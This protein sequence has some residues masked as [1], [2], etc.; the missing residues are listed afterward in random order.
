MIDYLARLATTS[1]LSMTRSKANVLDEVRT[2]MR[3]WLT[4]IDINRHV[5]N[6]RYLTLM[7]FARLDHSIRTGMMSA[8]LKRKWW[9][10]MG[11]ATVNFR[12]EIKPLMTFELTTKLLAYDDKWL[13]GEHRFERDGVVHATA[14]AKA[15]IKLGRTTVP[16]AE[17]MKV[18]GHDGPPPEAPEPLRRWIAMTNA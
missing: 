12:R 6:G 11:A 1:A 13:Y 18:M 14:Y 3:A 16:P 10:I 8:M 17:L 15:V 2:P 4:D 9:P 7:D 5:N